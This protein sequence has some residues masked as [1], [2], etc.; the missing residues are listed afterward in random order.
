VVPKIIDFG[1][2]KAVSQSLT[3]K[4]LF[5]EQGQLVGTP[6]Y[7]SPEQADEASEDIDTRSFAL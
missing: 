4:T 5:T 1:V 2:A 6:E 7:M 3:E